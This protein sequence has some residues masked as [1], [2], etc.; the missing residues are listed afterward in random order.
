MRELLKKRKKAFAVYVA[1]CLIPVITQMLNNYVF[2]RLLGSV[3]SQSMREFYISIY[4]AASFVIISTL[5]Y[6]LSRFLRIR[7]MRDTILDIRLQAFDKI[8]RS[9]LE[10]FGKKSKD[11]YVSNLINDINLFEQNFFFKLINIIFRGGVYIV[12]LVVLLILDPRFALA[13][14]AVSVVIF[15]ITKRFEKKTIAIQEDVSSRNEAFTVNVANTFNGLEILKLNN[16]EETFLDKTLK[17]IDRVESKKMHYG[18][19]AE[20]QRSI[21]RLLGTGIFVVIL[22]YMLEQLDQGLSIT[23]MTFM[24]Q[25]A[26]GCVWPLE[27]V[28][29]MINELKASVKIYDK[30][31]GNERD[32]MPISEGHRPFVFKHSI[33]IKNLSFQFEGRHVLREINLKIEKGKKYLLKGPSGSGKSTLIKLLSKVYDNYEGTIEIDGV[34]LK[35]I[36][37]SEFNSKVSFIFQDVFLFEDSLYNNI[38][39]FKPDYDEKV[40]N[41]V[42]KSGLSDMSEWDS[43][44][45]HM[46]LSEN[47]KNLSGGQRQ[48]ISIARAIAKDVDVLFAD[49]ATSSLDSELGRIIEETLLKMECTLIAVSHRTYEEVSELYDF[50]L[51]LKNGHLTVYSGIDY[52][53]EV[54]A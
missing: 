11:V 10:K 20:G 32:E 30:I 45:L 25:L 9:N 52:F 44:F 17:M 54:V 51:E 27:Q 21:T 33:E 42:A 22:I 26:N 6:I 53:E 16:I 4:I 14:F 8:L 38:S 48:R 3:E 46:Q 36:K 43:N 5:L 29:P 15:F 1:A 41:A 28:M 39:L 18:V 49:E 13:I 37:I 34:D 23:R 47:G 12:S 2:A 19:F 24:I 31:A 7:F 35:D 40:K 50:V